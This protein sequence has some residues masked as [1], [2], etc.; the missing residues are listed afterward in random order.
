MPQD[1]SEA[2]TIPRGDFAGPK[3]C[4]SVSGAADNND[5]I[6]GNSASCPMVGKLGFI[7]SRVVMIRIEWDR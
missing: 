1:G 3:L 2:L 5:A 6:E 4:S 7:A